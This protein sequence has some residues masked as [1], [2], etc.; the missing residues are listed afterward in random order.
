VVQFGPEHGNRSCLFAR[1]EA[2]WK[3][4]LSL[5][6]RG[7]LIGVLLILVLFMTVPLGFSLVDLWEVQAAMETLSLN[8]ERDLPESEAKVHADVLVAGRALARLTEL[9]VR[10]RRL[11]TT[12][13][14]QEGKRLLGALDAFEV[15]WGVFTTQDQQ[16]FSVIPGLSKAL[17]L[18][19]N[20][21]EA[22]TLAFQQIREH[23]AEAWKADLQR[24]RQEID[25][26]RSA[27]TRKKRKEASRRLKSEATVF[28][29]LLLKVQRQASASSNEGDGASDGLSA[30][31]AQV[32]NTT[33]IFLQEMV[34]TKQREIRRIGF[35]AAI[36]A[37]LS[38]FFARILWRDLLGP[39]ERL[40]VSINNMAMSGTPTRVD[41]RGP[42]EVADLLQ[43]Y[44]RLV[45]MIAAEGSQQPDQVP[46]SRC[47]VSIIQGAKFCPSCGFP[48]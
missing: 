9:V 24:L 47:A 16:A 7:K 30:V 27:R 44:N 14:A 8:Q 22:W 26:I 28:R 33:R 6:I 32:Q 15:L 2:K 45:D 34:E 39:L 11:T 38:L 19:E 31:S 42:P 23:K 46:C 41:T 17:A 3:G 40:R 21:H 36:G 29:N 10:C 13:S 1:I 12:P 48:Q 37:I 20:D 25:G 4:F 43:A 18:D 35:M 5:T